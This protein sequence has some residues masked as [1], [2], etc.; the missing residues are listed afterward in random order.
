MDDNGSGSG[1]GNTSVVWEIRH[2]SAA[3]PAQFRRLISPGFINGGPAPGITGA[4]TSVLARPSRGEVV[5]GQGRVEGHTDTRFNQIGRSEPPRKGDHPGKFRVRLRFRD[6][7]LAKMPEDYVRW[8]K[9]QAK[10]DD[11]L[12]GDSWFLE[13]DVPAIERTQPADNAEWEKMPWEIHW[14]W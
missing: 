14:E 4:A 7:D 6:D 12:A 8:I 3:N 2:G 9:Q 10:R 11:A 13:I 5:V 1:G